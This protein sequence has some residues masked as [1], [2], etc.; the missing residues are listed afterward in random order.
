MTLLLARWRRFHIYCSRHPLSAYTW[1][2]AALKIS[3]GHFVLDILCASIN[4]E[5]KSIHKF[6]GPPNYSPPSVVFY[7]ARAGFPSPSFRVI[8]G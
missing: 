2:A 6:K 4:Q 3:P 8:F 1:A 7:L 5:K